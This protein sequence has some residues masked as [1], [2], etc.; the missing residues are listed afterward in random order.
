[1]LKKHDISNK[2]LLAVVF[3]V[4]KFQQY[5]YGQKFIIETD[6]IALE[7]IFKMKDP[8]SLLTRFRLKLE[9]YD[10]K[11]K[12]IKGKRNVVSDAL[13]RI[14]IDSTAL[15]EMSCNVVTRLQKRKMQEKEETV[16]KDKQTE[17][18]KEST[19]VELLR[20][21]K[22][23]PQLKFCKRS[24]NDLSG[25]INITTDG[26]VGYYP[27]K[28]TVILKLPTLNSQT[29]LENAYNA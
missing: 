29:T 9:Q 8:Y 12:Y 7:S 10:F 22:D 15:K 4:K 20:P 6:H 14:E 24:L 25:E 16:Q 18:T 19:V 17:K 5:L 11:I 27:D 26:L 2:E 3:A 1:M 21:I 23:V 13:S 28:G